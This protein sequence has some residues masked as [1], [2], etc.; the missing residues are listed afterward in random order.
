[1]ATSP[2]LTWSTWNNMK[3][4][5]HTV[6]IWSYS[7]LGTYH[8]LEGTTRA[9][10][11]WRCN[12]S[13][14]CSSNVCIIWAS[15]TW[16]ACSE[17]R[18]LSIKWRDHWRRKSCKRRTCRLATEKPPTV[19]ALLKS[20][21]KSI[22]SS[23]LLIRPE[24]VYETQRGQ[25]LHQKRERLV[26]RLMYGPSDKVKVIPRAKAKSSRARNRRQHWS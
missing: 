13:T 10:S 11:R 4:N 3:R 15:E 2:S 25:Q 22:K 7:S 1:M 6:S 16:R 17:R 14:S 18:T 24:S 9:S 12:I 5:L 20:K 8:A 19:K 21:F 26:N 23:P